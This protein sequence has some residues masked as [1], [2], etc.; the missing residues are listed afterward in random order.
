V[1][2]LRSGRVS[3]TE[4]GA[5]SGF[6]DPGGGGIKAGRRAMGGGGD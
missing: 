4:R 6:Q 3:W 1:R 5:N 2:G